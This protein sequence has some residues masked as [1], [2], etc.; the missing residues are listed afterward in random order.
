MR[1]LLLGLLAVVIL[2]S[3]GTSEKTGWINGQEVYDKYHLTI[4]R[5]ESFINQQT[6]KKEILD[7]LKNNIIALENDLRVK[8]NPKKERVEKYEQLVQM[9]RM[10]LDKFERESS[11]TSNQYRAEILTKIQDKVKEYGKDHGY[12]YIYGD[13]ETGSTMYADESKEITNEII[14]YL[15]K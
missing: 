12:I 4:E 11:E 6:S 1:N 8:D 13:W 9:Y 15:N 2:A 7:S 10:Q 14:E 3:C 5:Q